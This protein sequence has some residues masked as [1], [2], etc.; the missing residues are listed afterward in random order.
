MEDHL[1]LLHRALVEHL[2]RDI[3]GGDV[4]SLAPRLVQHVGEQTHL[5][6]EAQDVHLGDV[7]LAA[8]DDD[9]LDEQ[10]R[11]GEIDGA[12]R[13]QAARLLAVERGVAGD[14]LGAVGLEDQFQKRRLFC[15]QLFLLLGF[16]EIGIDPDVV[17]PLVSP[18]IQNLKCPEILPLGFQLPLHADQPLGRGV[19]GEF[20][21]VGGDPLPPEFLRH[22]RRR[23]GSGEE[24]GDEI[25]ISHCD[26]SIGAGVTFAGTRIFLAGLAVSMPKS[27]TNALETPRLTASA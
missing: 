2:G 26:H 14:R 1:V 19:D 18:Q 12:D 7:L 10:P 13:D 11:D 4:D 6:L 15:F 3:L 8:L 21:Q 5:E 20:A 17:L 9:L 23:A 27:W 16:A 22:R 24:V 25:A